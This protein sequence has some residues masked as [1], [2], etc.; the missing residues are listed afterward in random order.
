MKVVDLEP[1]TDEW[2][3]WRR[4]RLTASEASVVMGEAPSWMETETWADLRSCKAG[5]DPEPDDWTKKAWEH[6]HKC[7]ERVL[8]ELDRAA[9]AYRPACLEMTSDSRFSA[10]IDGLLETF[11]DQVSGLWLE[12]KCPY[13]RDSRLLDV[14]SRLNETGEDERES[15]LRDLRP[16]IYWQLVQQAAVV[17]EDL[18]VSARHTCV[19]LGVDRERREQRVHLSVRNLLLDWPRLKAEWVRYMSGASQYR[20]DAEWAAAVERYEASGEHLE[21]AKQARQ[22]AR[23]NMIGIAGGEAAG[24]GYRVAFVKRR[25]T[26][27]WKAAVLDM[28]GGDEA[29]MNSIAENHRKS[30]SELWQVLPHKNSA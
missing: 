5:C 10:S 14:L 29:K 27:D 6:G 24:C 17:T 18:Q 11:R 7:E 20:E 25:G 13:R 28:A 15:L 8:A 22:Q 26:V 16:H 12:I 2:L 30:P 23:E 3:E 1:N 4:T 9:G 21:R 19:L